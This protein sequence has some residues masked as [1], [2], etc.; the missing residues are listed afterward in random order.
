L[1]GG[2]TLAR[3]QLLHQQLQ[4]AALDFDDIATGDAVLQEVSRFL[5]QVEARRTRSRSRAA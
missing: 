2:G 1:I 4:C 3:A 5:E